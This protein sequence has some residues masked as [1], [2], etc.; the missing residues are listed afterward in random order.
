M[1]RVGAQFVRAFNARLVERTTASWEF[2]FARLLR[3]ADHAGHSR[4]P[5]DY[6]DDDGY[7]LGSWATRQRGLYRRGELLADRAKRLAAVPGWV[8]DE[9]K[10]AWEEAYD[11]LRAFAQR[12]GHSRVAQNYRTSDGF[13][14]GRWVSIQRRAHTRGE[15]PVERV[16]QLEALPGWDW[17][18]R[19]ERWERGYTQLLR[20]ADREGNALVPTSHVENRFRL[21]RWVNKQRALYATGSLD[22]ARRRRLEGVAGWTW[23]TLEGSW[24]Q[25]Y[26]RLRAYSEREGHSRVPR[27]YQT[28]D[29]FDLGG[30]V[31]TQRQN[32]SRRRLSVERTQLLEALPGWVWN[33][34]HAAWEDGYARVVPYVDREGDSRVPVTYRDNDG[35]RLGSWANN[36][37]A[38]QR[39]GG[40]HPERRRR[41]EA[42]PG[43]AKDTRE[44]S[45]EKGCERLMRYRRTRGS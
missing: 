25:A 27:H 45:W 6:R 31:R 14:L 29:G 37:R 15:M 8:W 28:D 19:D 32:R 10:E 17:A 30:W 40:C 24:Q 44:A 22:S 21:G 35:Y 18:P 4:V 36:Q 38:A 9:R 16:R 5:D 42:L 41:L 11:R 33:A 1:G 26:M 3:F 12:E 34:L 13:R 43:W 2:G 7:E 39:R 23:D 20:Y